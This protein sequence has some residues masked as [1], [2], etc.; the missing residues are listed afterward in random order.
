MQN[1]MGLGLTVSNLL[2][3]LM[4]GKMILDWTEEGK[5]TKFILYIPLL[6]QDEK[7]HSDIE[8]TTKDQSPTETIIK[9]SYDKLNNFGSDSVNLIENA[10]DPSP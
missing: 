3:E 8:I 4:G 10:E 5:G 9:A 7:S 6:N 2:V 1:G